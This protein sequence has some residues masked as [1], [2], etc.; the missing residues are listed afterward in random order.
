MNT[1]VPYQSTAIYILNTSN[2]A[3]VLQ[4]SVEPYL[5]PSYWAELVSSLPGYMQSELKVMQF[6]R[7]LGVG[8]GSSFT[9]TTSFQVGGTTVL[10]QEKV[11]GTATGST[12]QQQI[13]AG[14]ATTGWQDFSG[15]GQPFQ[16]IGEDH[17]TYVVN[18]DLTTNAAAF[19]DIHYSIAQGT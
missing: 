12:L 17:Q 9:F 4:S 16:F 13:T 15:K 7:D 2:Q 5:A 3:L 19:T 6:S 11:V 1:N 18:W 8:D 14:D 10:F